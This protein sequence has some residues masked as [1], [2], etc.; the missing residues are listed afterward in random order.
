VEADIDRALEGADV[1]MTLRLQRE[2]QQS[3]LLP[4]VREYIRRFQVT[5]GRLQ[6]AKGNVLLMHPGPVNED[7]E[8]TAEAACG[9]Q[10]VIDEQVANGVAVRMAI[11]YLLSGRQGEL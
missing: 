6:R 11:L 2:R 5:S 4:S 8:L 7:V 9:R 1:V 3:G 10:S